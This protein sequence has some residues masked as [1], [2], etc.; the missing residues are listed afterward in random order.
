MC[1]LS[2]LTLCSHL[3][4]SGPDHEAAEAAEERGQAVPLPALHQHAHLRRHRC[5]RPPSQSARRRALLG[6]LTFP[7]LR[8]SLH[9]LHHL[10]HQDLPDE[11]V[12]VCKLA[13]KSSAFPPVGPSGLER[14]LH[15][16]ASPGLEGDVDRRRLLALPVLHHPAGHHVPVATVGQ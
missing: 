2:S 13:L 4:E 8:F 10:D 9:Y 7:C 11:R 14:F 15:V 6:Y 1:C 3:R 12:S 5:R 16:S